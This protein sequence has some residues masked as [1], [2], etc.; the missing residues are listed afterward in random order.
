MISHKI[1]PGEKGHPLGTK[2][3]ADH[4]TAPDHIQGKMRFV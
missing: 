3:I 2:H 1:T 4:H